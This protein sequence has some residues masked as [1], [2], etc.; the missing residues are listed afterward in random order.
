MT[1]DKWEDE[2][3][4]FYKIDSADFEATK[5]EGKCKFSQCGRDKICSTMYLNPARFGTLVP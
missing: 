5:I 1:I 2:D 4:D 3:G